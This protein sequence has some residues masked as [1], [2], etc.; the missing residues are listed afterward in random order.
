MS[1]YQSTDRNSEHRAQ[2]VALVD[3][4]G[5]KNEVDVCL[6]KGTRGTPFINSIEL[7]ILPATSY[8]ETKSRQDLLSF[9]VLGDRLNMGTKPTDNIPFR[10]P[11]DDFDRIWWPALPPKYPPYSRADGSS[12]LSN[13]TFC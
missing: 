7:R 13:L 2:W 9:L 11:D 3:S 6:L 5:Q 4:Y 8:A 10:F 12:I 1:L